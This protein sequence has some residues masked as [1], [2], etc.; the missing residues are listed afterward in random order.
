MSNK[1][2]FFENDFVPINIFPSPRV[3]GQGT[4]FSKERISPSEAQK[5]FIQIEKINFQ[6]IRAV[7]H[8]DKVALCS[9]I[10]ALIR[11]IDTVFEFSHNYRTSK[12]RKEMGG[13]LLNVIQLEQ[14]RLNQ[15]L[16][17]KQSSFQDGLKAKNANKNF[18][19]AI[20]NG[21]PRKIS[22]LL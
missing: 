16:S 7:E 11:K 1:K 22:A 14:E 17:E 10:N 21:T 20:L 3:E 18:Y 19:D 13:L 12:I 5:L 4:Y 6:Y 15:R 2:D 9:S 8:S